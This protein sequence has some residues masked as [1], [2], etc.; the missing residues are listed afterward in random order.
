MPGSYTIVG[1]EKNPITKGLAKEYYTSQS[2]NILPSK[3]KWSLYL[4][5]RFRQ[6]TRVT[7]KKET[8]YTLIFNFKCSSFLC[9]ISVRYV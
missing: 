9:Q 8:A 3:V 6:P 4:R 2:T 7:M 5:L 1:Q